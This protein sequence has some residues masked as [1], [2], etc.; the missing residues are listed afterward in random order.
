[1]MRKL[2]AGIA[3]L[4][5]IGFAPVALA[6]EVSPTEDNDV[7]IQDNQ[8]VT[9]VCTIV[10][11]QTQT[12]A[13][14]QEIPVPEAEEPSESDPAVQSVVQEQNLDQRCGDITVI[15]KS[16]VNQPTSTPS[17][18]VTPQVVTNTVERIVE[19]IVEKDAPRVA[20]VPAGA[21]ETGR[22]GL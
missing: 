5:L 13:S 11:N 14:V 8:V 12:N 3:L 18:T 21:P 22:G 4:M 15:I 9:I 2:I 20:V 1:M 16:E 10:G 7:T 17:A 19:K 6:Q